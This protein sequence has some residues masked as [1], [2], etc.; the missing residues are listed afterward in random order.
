MSTVIENRTRD[1]IEQ[2]MR[3]AWA[4]V[5]GTD[6]FGPDDS[7]FT[8]GGDS[9]TAIRLVGVCRAGGVEMKVA[10]VFL[11]PVFRDLVAFL[12]GPEPAGPPPAEDQARLSTTLADLDPALVP[13]GVVDAYPL[14]AV[15]LGMLYHCELDGDTGLY[16][17]LTSCEIRGRWDRAA[18]EESLAVLCDRHDVLRTSFDL[19]DFPEPLQLVHARA[20]VPVEVE[21]LSALDRTGQEEALAGWWAREAGVP[22][23]LSTAPLLRVHVGLRSPHSFQLSL[24]VHHIL[25]DGWSYARLVTELLTEYA[26][27]TA[28]TPTPYDA[29]PALPAL[30]GVRYRDFI[31]HEQRAVASADSRDF[32]TGLLAGAAV[33]PLPAPDGSGRGEAEAEA[34]TVRTIPAD[35]TAGVRRV[36]NELRVPVKSVHL[37][38]YLHT[39]SALSQAPDVVGGICGSSRPEREGAELVLGVFINVLPV[40]LVVRGGTWGELVTAAFEAERAHLPHRAYPLARIQRDLGRAPFETMFNFTDLHAFDAIGT[41]RG[42]EADGWRFAD[43][44]N[45]PVVVEVNRRPLQEEVFDLQVRVDPEATAAAT[46]QRLAELFLEALARL[47]ADHTAAY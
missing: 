19:A 12:G 46:G 3:T 11:H 36:A 24:S 44:T 37:A 5:L 45:F 16:H 33:L 31:A 23:D 18:L 20:V 9:I 43:R 41:L 38:A 25:V 10:Q 1:R 6:A 32:W 39:L 8:L 21:D 28:P 4:E 47:T 42:V 27:R 30:S 29:A 17:D 13:A 14:S 34:L 7:F 35:L 2:T 15:Q 22:F 40:R 26:R